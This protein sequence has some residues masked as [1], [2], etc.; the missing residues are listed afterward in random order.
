M[1]ADVAKRVELRSTGPPIRLRSGQAEAVV[2][3]QELKTKTWG[4]KR[5]SNPQPPEPQSGALPVELFPP[6]ESHYS[7]GSAE[8]VRVSS[9]RDLDPFPFSRDLNPKDQD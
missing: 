9:Q 4:G 2:P 1:P 6:Q 7:N 3:A 8:A 5:E